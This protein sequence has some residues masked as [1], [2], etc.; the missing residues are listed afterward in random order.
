MMALKNVLLQFSITS[1]LCLCLLLFPSHAF[2]LSLDIPT[3]EVNLPEVIDAFLSSI[4]KDYYAVQNIDRLKNTDNVLVIDV[5]EPSEY[6]TGHIPKAI[7]IPLRTLTQNL[8][9]IPHDQP[10]I[11]LYWLPHRHGRNEL[12]IIGIQ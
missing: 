9:Q 5:R 8:T 7:N 3:T 10:V 4:P 2:S 11:L 1:T 6:L 12:T